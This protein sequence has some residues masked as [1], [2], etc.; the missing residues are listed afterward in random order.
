MERLS[1]RMIFIVAFQLGLVAGSGPHEFGRLSRGATNLRAQKEPA[2]PLK[3]FPLVTSVGIQDSKKLNKTCCLNGGTCMLGTFC[4]CP[5][6]FSGRNCE[7]DVR[8]WNCGSVSH[9][10][11]MFKKC[12]MCRCWEGQL[13]CLLLPEC[14]SLVIN[15]HL[16]AS[17]TPELAPSSYTTLVLVGICLSL[18]FY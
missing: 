9:G 12:S 18:L 10:A 16:E 2:N 13:H 6:H 17:R 7:Q 11:W 3:P 8:R 5:P 1:T 15:E 14:G 4:A